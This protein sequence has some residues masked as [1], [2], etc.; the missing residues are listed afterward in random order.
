MSTF[1]T[2]VDQEM[3]DRVESPVWRRTL[4]CLSFLHACVQERRRFGPQ[5]WTVAYEFSTSDLTVSPL[6]LNAFTI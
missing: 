6:L 2:V 5:A 3:I 4:F 1:S